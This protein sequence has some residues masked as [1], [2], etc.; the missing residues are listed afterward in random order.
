[1]HSIEKISAAAPPGKAGNWGRAVPGV[2][3]KVV[4]PATGRELAAGETGVLH[5]RGH[6]LM[7]GYYKLEREQVFT[8][9]GWFATGDL[10][11]LDE[12]GYVYFHGRNTEMIKTAGANVS[13]KEVEL[14]LAARPGVREAIVF[15]MPDA[16]K[17]EI[18]V[19]VVVP[20]DGQSLD[21]GNLRDQLKSEISPYKIPQEIIF[22]AFEDIPRTGSQKPRKR[23]LQ[24]SLAERFQGRAI[25][26]V[27]RKTGASS[28]RN[29]R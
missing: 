17:G 10:A 15:G 19:A 2:E 18:V 11:S 7:Q 28:V 6:T 12:D 27:G 8:R 3:R 4:D 9:D 21:A 1:M 13:P 20:F 24:Q 26:V 25:P 29:T 22:M 23:D 16:A 5:I 14:A